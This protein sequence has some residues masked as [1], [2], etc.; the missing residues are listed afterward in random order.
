MLTGTS[1][2]LVALEASKEIHDTTGAEVSF[3]DAWGKSVKKKKEARLA[4]L[5]KDVLRPVAAAA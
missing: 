4:R 2:R 3:E 5:G 1:F